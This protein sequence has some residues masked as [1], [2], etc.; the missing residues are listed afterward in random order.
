MM[1]KFRGAL[2]GVLLGDCLGSPYEGD[3][4]VSKIMLQKYFD[5]MEDP[6]FKSPIKKYTD[7]TVMTK[8]IASSFVEH[9]ALNE[10]DIAKR[11]VRNFFAEP[12]RGYGEGVVNVFRKLRESKFTDI[13]RPAR[14]QFNGS[15]S[16]GN[17][18]AMRVVPVSLFCCSNYRLMLDTAEKCT[19][20]THTHKLGVNG[21]LL[22]AIALQQSFQLAPNQA[23]DVEGFSSNLIN[24]MEAVEAT[25]S[26][27][28]IDDPHRQT[29]TYQ[30]QL[31]EMQ[32]LLKKE[33]ATD[34]EV[35]EALG[36][37]VQALYSVPTAIYCFLR[38]QR[39]I[40]SIQTDNKFTRTLQYSI[41]LGGDTDTIASMAGALSGAYHGYEYISTGLQAH[42][43]GVSDIIKLADDL[44]SRTPFI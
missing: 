38:A 35:L 32:N 42:C 2:V 15:G 27:E 24:K 25:V 39:P 8:A 34:D 29:H 7:D 28:D 26:D 19:K 9:G 1:S 40:N 5:K 30:E 36:N 17:G 44:Y 6:R 41:S 13:W 10:I 3:E 37:G 22:Q 11:F 20:I 43:E 18:G 21:A 4:T 14:E 31:K 33:H 12:G 16:L 23:I